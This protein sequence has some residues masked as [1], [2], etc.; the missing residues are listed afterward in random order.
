MGNGNGRMMETTT[1]ELVS[2]D[3]QQSGKTMVF[4]DLPI[5]CRSNF[6]HAPLPLLKDLCRQ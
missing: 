3:Q 6:H 4:L 5:S 2:R 1:I